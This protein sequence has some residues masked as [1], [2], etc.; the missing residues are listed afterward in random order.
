MHSTPRSTVVKVAIIAFAFAVCV[1]ATAIHAWRAGAAKP[2]AAE[3]ISIWDLHNNA[4]LDNLPVQVIE[5][6]N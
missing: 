4:H 3:G 2:V 5:D 1:G 6:Y